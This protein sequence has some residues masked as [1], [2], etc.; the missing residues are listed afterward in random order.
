MTTF[1]LTVA[2]SADA[3]IARAHDD[4]PQNWASA[5]EQALFFQ[6]VEAADWAIMGRNTHQAA[7]KPHRRR[8]IFSSTMSGW[9][10][11][12]QLWLEPA[13]LAP[14]ALAPLVSGVYPLN[15]G[16]ILGGT[17]VH[18]WFLAYDAI[19]MVNLTVEP[20][21]FG[22]GLPIFGKQDSQDPVGV[23]LDRGFRIASE[24][25]LNATG[26]TYYKLERA[27]KNDGAASAS[28]G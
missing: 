5:E 21:T 23:F 24:D 8:I 12:S 22:G 10:R 9:H 19:D 11:P 14:A 13:E 6:D 18:D 17:S 25:K 20:V 15:Q 26:T 16:L 7:D 4:A 27:R 1:T 2:T 28:A 3:Y